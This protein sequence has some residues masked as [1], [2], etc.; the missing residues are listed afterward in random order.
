MRKLRAVIACQLCDW[1]DEGVCVS[2]S[3][4]YYPDLETKDEA[5]QENLEAAL[6]ELF[7]RSRNQ[8]ARHSADSHG[9]E[10]LGRQFHCRACDQWVAL[11]DNGVLPKHLTGEDVCENFGVDHFVRLASAGLPSLGKGSR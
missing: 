2:I 7:R 6:D 8:L 4:D 9:A 5:R 3:N 11:N 1:R 10:R